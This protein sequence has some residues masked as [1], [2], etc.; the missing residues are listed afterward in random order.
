VYFDRRWSKY[1]TPNIYLILLVYAYGK[2]FKS[3]QSGKAFYTVDPK[4]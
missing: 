1:T 3:Y 4:S 2:V